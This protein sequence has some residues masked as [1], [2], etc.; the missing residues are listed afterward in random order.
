MALSAC[1]KF[2]DTGTDN[3]ADDAPDLVAN[4]D[5]KSLSL[6]HFNLAAPA[7]AIRG[8]GVW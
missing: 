7:G 1:V 2:S 6:T 5:H 8:C 4:N 3:I